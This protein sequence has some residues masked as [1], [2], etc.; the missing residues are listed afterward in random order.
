MNLSI[1]DKELNR[2][3]IIGNRFVS[4]LWSEGYNTIQPFTL[5]LD[6]TD[7]YKRTVKPD[8]YVSRADRKTLMVIK[9]VQVANNKIVASGKQAAFCLDDVSFI[10]TIQSGAIVDDT[11]YKEYN[12]TSKFPLFEFIPSGLPDKYLH[13]ISNKSFAE[14]MEKICQSTDMGFK[15]VRDGKT[16]AVKLYKPEQKPNLV[17][18]EYIGNLSI[19]KLLLST[20]KLKNYAIVLGEGE[21]AAR[22]RVDVDMSNGQQKRV[23]IFDARNIRKEKEDTDETYRKKLESYGAEKLLDHRKTWE[24]LFTPIA[25]DFGVKFDLG[26]IMTV[27]LPEYGLRLQARVAR[28][29]QKEQKNSVSTSIEVGEITIKR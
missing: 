3:A 2:I 19:D 17:F 24:C 20:E 28:F 11:L 1:Y 26:D 4:C 5:E 9:T 18:S 7:E 15:V 12:K 21:G 6:A 22:V 25:D 23:K 27:L 14:L 10:G 13:D 16:A 29:T 8:Y